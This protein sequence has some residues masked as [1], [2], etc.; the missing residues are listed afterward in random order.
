MKRNRWMLKLFIIG[1]WE[2]KANS[3]LFISGRTKTNE[4]KAKAENEY[5]MSSG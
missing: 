2:N 1:I 4:E 5:G 3:Q